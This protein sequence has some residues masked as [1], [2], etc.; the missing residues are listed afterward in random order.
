MDFGAGEK[1]SEDTM[2]QLL[3]A[4]GAILDEEVIEHAAYDRLVD[5][6]VSGMTSGSFCLLSYISI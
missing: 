1:V 6:L 5:A 4:T 3:V 2:L